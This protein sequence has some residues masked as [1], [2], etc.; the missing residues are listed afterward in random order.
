MLLINNRR[1]QWLKMMTRDADKTA[2]APVPA[3]VLP[4]PQTAN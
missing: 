1:K 3:L 4:D 2:Q